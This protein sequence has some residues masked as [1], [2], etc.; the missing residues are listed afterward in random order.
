MEETTMPLDLNYYYG[1]EA[2]QF[3]FY[4]IPKTLLTDPRYKTY[5]LKPK[6]F[7]ACCWTAWAC[8]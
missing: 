4:R 2:D 1:N 7:M 5:P 6:F 3:S 8:L